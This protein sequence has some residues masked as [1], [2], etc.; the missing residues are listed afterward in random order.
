MPGV[1]GAGEGARGGQGPE[2]SQG[3]AGSWGAARSQAGVRQLFC[4]RQPPGQQTSPAGEEASH[5]CLE[6]VEQGNCSASIKKNSQTCHFPLN[7]NVILQMLRVMR[8]WCC[9]CTAFSTAFPSPASTPFCLSHSRSL[10]TA[11]PLAGVTQGWG[12]APCSSVCSHLHRAR[13][14]WFSSSYPSL[15]W[16]SRPFGYLH[17]LLLGSSLTCPGAQLA[18]LSLPSNSPG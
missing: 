14:K 3:H 10:S 17:H 9:S 16:K 6:K 7:G 8:E 2:G 5:C 15:Q 18:T 1:P 12:E 4:C 13:R 11:Q